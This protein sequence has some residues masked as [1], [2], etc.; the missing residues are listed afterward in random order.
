MDNKQDILWPVMHD[1]CNA[2]NI[3][4]DIFYR[5]SDHLSSANWIT[6]LNNKNNKQSCKFEKF[7]VPL[8]REII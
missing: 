2:G 6:D 3:E 5:H 4:K 1:F 7:V 8:Q